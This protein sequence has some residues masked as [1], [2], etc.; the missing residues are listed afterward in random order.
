MLKVA[1]S[2]SFTTGAKLAIVCRELQVIT[3]HHDTLGE[4]LVDTALKRISF[5]K[6]NKPLS[7]ALAWTYDQPSSKY[8]KIFQRRLPAK[9]Q[10]WGENR[11]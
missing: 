10:F 5:T 11:D 7:F 3:A 9:W 8:H 4:H 1:C 2:K 6:C